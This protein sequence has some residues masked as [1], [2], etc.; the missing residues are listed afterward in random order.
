MH[1]NTHIKYKLYRAFNYGKRIHEIHGELR[2]HFIGYIISH[3]AGCIQIDIKTKKTNTERS[4]WKSPD[5]RVLQEEKKVD[6]F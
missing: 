3:A 2:Q 6:V 1:T 4:E 5:V